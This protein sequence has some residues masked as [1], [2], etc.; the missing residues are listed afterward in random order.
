MRLLPRTILSFAIVFVAFAASLVSLRAAEPNYSRKEVIYGRKFGT[1]LTMDVFAPKADANGAGV[2]FVV[3]GGWYSDHNGITG[4]IPVWVQPLVDKGFTVFAVVHGSN[5]KFALPEI[6]NDMNRA[7]RFIRH[8]A[9]EYGIDRD[10]IGITGG[11]AGGHLSLLQGCGGGDGN[12]KGDEIDR[13]SSRVQAVVAFYPPTDFLNWGEK[14]K[15]MLGTHPIVPVKGAFDFT[16]L[17]QKTNSFELIT[18]EKEREAI[19]REMS[20]LYHVAEDNPPTLI[21]HGDKD[22]LVPL[23]QAQIMEAKMKEAG[24]TVELIVKPGGGH[25]GALVKEY[26]PQSVAWFVKYLAK[27]AP[28]GAPAAASPTSSLVPSTPAS[29]TTSAK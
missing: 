25:D 6:F 12:P 22:L 23:Q 8:N 15:V 20:P 13:E 24:A 28:S 29:K 16:R 17:A 14:G 5:P 11:S 26:Q 2:I 19:G 27:P 1:A 3:S 9:A 10:R 21:I 18:D 4:N 7:V